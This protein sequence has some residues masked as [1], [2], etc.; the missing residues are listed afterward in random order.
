MAL[1]ITE[2]TE[3]IR[4]SHVILWRAE[5]AVVDGDLEKARELVNMIRNRVK[6][7][8]PV[9]GRCLSTNFA[10]D[11]ELVVDW[12]QPAAN[13]KTEPYPAGHVAFFFSGTSLESGQ[14]RDPVGIC[15]GR[16]SVF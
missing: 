2:I 11:T 7:S 12:E 14:N 8:T 4:Y 10:E 15:Y 6:T 13:Y 9:M 5:C 1:T 3:Y 16:T